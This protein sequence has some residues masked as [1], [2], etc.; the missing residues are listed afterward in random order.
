MLFLPV[1]DDLHRR[2]QLAEWR[3]LDLLRSPSYKDCLEAYHLFP[4]MTIEPPEQKKPLAIQGQRVNCARCPWERPA[5][6]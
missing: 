4:E 1:F 5:S 2:E 6:T 3:V